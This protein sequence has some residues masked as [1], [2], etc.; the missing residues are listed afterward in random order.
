MR[1]TRRVPA[2]VPG[3]VFL[4]GGLSERSR[5]CSSQHDEQPT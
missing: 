4:S 5:V 1:E 3:V 2:S